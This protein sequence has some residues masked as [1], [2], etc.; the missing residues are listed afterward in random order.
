M[1]AAASCANCGSR[2]PQRSRFCPECGARAGPGPVPVELST[3]ARPRAGFALETLSTHSA[4]GW[5][6]SGRGQSWLI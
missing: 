4:R 2:L 1:P 3:A 6:C 5:S